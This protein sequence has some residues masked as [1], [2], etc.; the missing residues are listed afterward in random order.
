MLLRVFHGLSSFFISVFILKFC[1]FSSVKRIQSSATILE[2]KNVHKNAKEKG[3]QKEQGNE[4][5]FSSGFYTKFFLR[6]LKEIRT[7]TRPESQRAPGD[8]KSTEEGPR[9]ETRLYKAKEGPEVKEEE[10]PQR[11][12]GNMK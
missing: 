1:S 4:K 12:P 11:Q 5:R 9:N 10:I 8:T 2:R 7:R 6:F 3:D